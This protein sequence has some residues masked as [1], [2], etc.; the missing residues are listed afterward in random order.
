MKYKLE[1]IYKSLKPFEIELPNF[2]ILTGI[3]G[4]GKTQV[5]HALT[6][7]QGQLARIAIADQIIENHQIKYIDKLLTPND[8]HPIDR[9]SI[10]ESE[11]FEL[12]D[13]LFP[14]YLLLLNYLAEF[15][16][17]PKTY[18][19][20]QQYNNERYGHQLVN[21]VNF[22]KIKEFI[23]NISTEKSQ[24]FNFFKNNFPRNYRPQV[25]E[26]FT[27][28]FSQ[29]FRT[30]QSLIFKNEFNQFLSE[31]KGKNT[32]F[33]QGDEFIHVNGNPP[34]EIINNIIATA[35]LD[36]MFEVPNDYDPNITYQPKFI[37]KSTGDSVQISE[38]SSGEKI[39]ISL[40]FALYNKDYVNQIPKLI[41]LDETD[42]SLHPSMAKQYL[43]ILKNVFVKDLGVK[44][45]ITTHSPSTV[46]LAD[47]QDIFVVENSEQRI[48]KCS[49]D[50]A[51]S[52]LTAG[53]PSLSINYEN[54]KQVFVESPFDVKYYDAI[55]KILSP[56]LNKEVSLNFISSGDSRTDKNGDPVA[57]S[58]QVK[59]ITQTLR[60][61]GNKSCFGIIDWDLNNLESEEGII[62][63]S[64]NNQ[65]SIENC[66]LNP[67]FIGLLILL[68]KVGPHNEVEYTFRNLDS[69][70]SDTLNTIHDWI[71][72]KISSQFTTSDNNFT[73]IELNN[74]LVIKTPQWF[75][76]HQGH[77]L[78][79]KSCKLYLN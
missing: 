60:K 57:N 70:C 71:L 9:Y 12:H 16:Q 75:T 23:E 25:N 72:T 2:V 11:D 51:L 1:K 6:Q 8:I 58:S 40:A 63:N 79:K 13:Q 46:A 52:V 66:L 5:L 69:S 68:T 26:L 53:V 59:H 64:L 78:E 3:N 45:I 74:S 39:L 33:L 62:V 47:E 61:H 32:N 18:E 7:N 50:E 54:R 37:K 36:Y 28:N 42:A 15:G 44:I 22:K 21:S 73:S 49:K 24:D 4:V 31:R 65:Y 41:L 56:Y 30:Y 38:L 19:I 34:W 10:D 48:R 20:F 67:L 17:L 43:N 35:T 55:Y 14:A 29:I 77:E 27:H 76:H